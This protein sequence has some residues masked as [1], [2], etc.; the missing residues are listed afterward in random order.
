MKNE[1]KQGRGEK[2]GWNEVTVM[3]QMTLK[4][5]VMLEWPIRLV[6]VVAAGSASYSCR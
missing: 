1:A 3:P 6:W 2:L 4:H 5:Q